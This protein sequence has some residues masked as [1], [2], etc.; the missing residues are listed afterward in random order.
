MVGEEIA[1]MFDMISMQI[2]H[3]E[4][5]VVIISDIATNPI[6]AAYTEPLFAGLEQMPADALGLQ[7]DL[8]MAGSGTWKDILAA[9]SMKG[10]SGSGGLFANV[11]ISEA[12]RTFV[13]EMFRELAP[14]EIMVQNNT[15]REDC[16]SLLKQFNGMSLH[17]STWG[18]QEGGYSVHDSVNQA[19]KSFNQHAPPH[20]N[21]PITDADQM[22]YKNWNDVVAC[23]QQ[24]NLAE[25]VEQLGPM[26]QRP[27]FHDFVKAVREHG[28]WEFRECLL[29]DSVQ[30]GVRSK[31]A[32]MTEVFDTL[33]GMA[34]P[35]K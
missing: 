1:P 23:A 16:V 11:S 25:K 35:G 17:A 15:T 21:V 3:H 26:A 19:L 20:M 13:E 6:A 8:K 31:S 22:P 9:E 24:Q 5:N 34:F 33:Y 28:L 18:H 4:D 7:M 2:G 14:E 10:V 29:V 30:L 32:G 12:G 27:L